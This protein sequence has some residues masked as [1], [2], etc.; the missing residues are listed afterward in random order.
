MKKLNI[1]L[2]A[3]LMVTSMSSRATEKEEPGKT[4]EPVRQSYEYNSIASTVYWEGSKPGG[5]HHGTIEVVNGSA[6]MEGEMIT[7]GKFELDMSTIRNEDVESDAMRERL[8]NHLKS[9]DFFYVE[10]YPTSTFTITGLEQTEDDPLLYSVTG[11]LTIRGITREITF[12]A[13]IT[14]DDRMI[15]VRTGEIILNRTLWEVNHQSRSIFAELK[16]NFI[17]DEMVV[18]LDVHLNRN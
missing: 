18:R 14:M 12:P 4:T 9:E 7:G 8:V 13:A 5:S 17:D 6:M 3:A 2:M 11:D 1:Y 10:I 16:D 15:N